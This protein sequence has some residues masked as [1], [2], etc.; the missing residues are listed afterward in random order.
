MHE[1]LGETQQRDF[2][3]VDGIIVQVTDEDGHHR[4]GHLFGLAG[5]VTGSG[6]GV[7]ARFRFFTALSLLFLLPAD[8]SEGWREGGRGEGGETKLKKANVT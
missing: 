6:G 8:E 7:G 2:S 3:D 1:Q 4:F 5:I